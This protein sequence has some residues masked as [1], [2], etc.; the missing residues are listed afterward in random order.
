MFESNKSL[1][2][3]NFTFFLP[4]IRRALCPERVR[5]KFNLEPLYL[6][7]LFLIVVGLGPISMCKFFPGASLVHPWCILGASL[8]H[9]WCILG[10]SLYPSTWSQGLRFS[11]KNEYILFGPSQAP[12]KSTQDARRQPQV[13]QN[14][15][16]T[17][18][19]HPN[20]PPKEPPRPRQIH[21][22]GP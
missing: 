2:S 22:K 7:D 8:V 10:A 6:L 20:S 18:P 19:K 17:L 3:Q 4:K 14:P 16:K 9:P 12:L 1:V 13:P 21:L 11:C 5:S 15:P